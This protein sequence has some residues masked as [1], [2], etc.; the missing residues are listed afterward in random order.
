MSGSLVHNGAGKETLS[1]ILEAASEEFAANGY[2]GARMD[3]IARRARVNK[4][5]LYYHVGDKD[6][7]YGAVLRDVF[8]DIS[9]ELE[10]SLESAGPP[11]EKLRAFVSS[12]A[13]IIA[14]RKYFSM[15]V[16]RELASGFGNMPREVMGTIDSILSMYL[17]IVNSG[18]EAGEF[19]QDFNPMVGYAMI[20]GCLHF[21]KAGWNIAEGL[22]DTEF[23]YR[24]SVNRPGPEVVAEELT[25][26]LL[27][28]IRAETDK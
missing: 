3:R 23:S 22:S 27:A 19:R 2:A 24:A 6:A 15:I 12:I 16:L 1:R 9:S 20:L 8:S 13:S 4:A 11:R 10:R 14:G 18:K 21:L 25:R 26:N 5:A 17:D 7:L 28:A